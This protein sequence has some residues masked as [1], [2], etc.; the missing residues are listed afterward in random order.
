M[1][2][3]MHILLLF[4]KGVKGII[5]DEAAALCF[6]LLVPTITTEQTFPCINV[7]VKELFFLIST[8]DFLH[9]FINQN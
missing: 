1:D 8:C 4:Y 9:V 5:K 7:H 6:Y 3:G 2:T